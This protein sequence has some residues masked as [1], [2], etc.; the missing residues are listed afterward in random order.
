MLEL[1]LK[2]VVLH[3]GDVFASRCE[4]VNAESEDN[5]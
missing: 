2:T 1:A 4:G 3:V 5:G